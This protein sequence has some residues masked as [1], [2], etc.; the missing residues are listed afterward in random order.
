MGANS[1]KATGALGTALAL[2]VCSAGTAAETAGFEFGVE[3]P[4][5]R[6]APKRQKADPKD[7]RFAFRGRKTSEHVL[8]S[9]RNESESFQLV[10]LPKGRALKRVT[11]RFSDLTG[12]G[13]VIGK[14]NCD[15]E[16]VGQVKTHPCKMIGGHWHRQAKFAPKSDLDNLKIGWTCD[17]LLRRNVFDVLA[18]EP[19]VVWVTLYVLARTKPGSY[20]GKITVEADGL[21]RDFK[22]RVE[23]WP[24]TIPLRRP[25]VTP[26]TF[27]PDTVDRYYGKLDERRRRLWYYFF[28]RHN[29]D[30]TTLYAKK[31]QP[32]KRYIPWLVDRGLSFIMFGGNH[33]SADIRDKA[34]VKAG[35][36]WLKSNGYLHLAG[37]WAMDEPSKPGVRNGVRKCKWVRE[38][39]PGLLTV[40][41]SRPVGELYG[42]L[43]DIWTS[44]A[45]G[46]TTS[47][48]VRVA[49][50]RMNA[51]EA[52]IY[53]CAAGP[54][55][56][57]PNIQI[58]WPLIDARQLGWICWK[59]GFIGFEYYHVNIW[60]HHKLTKKPNMESQRRQW[61]KLCDSDYDPQRSWHTYSFVSKWSGYNGDGCLIYPG[62]GKMPWASVRLA[63]FRDGV[64]DYSY[65]AYLRDALKG[66]EAVAP[67]SPLMARFS[68]LLRVP[69]KVIN[70]VP[71]R[72]PDRAT[73]TFDPEFEK[74]LRIRCRE[75]GPM[76]SHRRKLGDA[77]AEV[78]RELF[79]H[80]DRVARLVEADDH[81]LKRFKKTRPLYPAQEPEVT[82]Q[83][84]RG[85]AEEIDR[86]YREA[87]KKSRDW[88]K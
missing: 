70:D 4:V 54:A 22:L 68:P 85:K 52:F 40:L 86:E 48:S 38:N 21:A 5:V 1:P 27:N 74:C 10:I 56:P 69:G 14:E 30:P 35:Y 36:E 43:A 23:V 88:A 11:V 24:F 51:G 34:A 25:M 82:G 79:R 87:M 63:N 44:T 84:R 41:G 28:L 39:C 19:R 12:P 31:M 8:W 67:Q 75:P 6:I 76:E 61:Y 53:A 65:F 83:W 20:R 71:R 49:R 64:D 33:Y 59:W 81:I 62:Y 26:V 77:I 9:A 46:R 7:T 80:K 42:G 37:L 32:E 73:G 58:D 60:G 15:F 78:N 3:S 17:P 55:S 47:H 57:Y 29:M 18:D 2:L 66:L 45:T 72:V 13:G 16:I 50:E